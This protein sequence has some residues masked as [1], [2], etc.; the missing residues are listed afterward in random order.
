M[1]RAAVLALTVALVACGDPAVDD[2]ADALGAEDPKVPEGPSHRPGQPCLA[3]HDGS[4]ADVRRFSVAGTIYTVEGGDEV[5]AGAIVELVDAFGETFRVATNC[6][7][8]FYVEPGAYDPTYPVWVA[9]ESGDDRIEMESPIGRDGSCATCH[10]H[11]AGKASAGRVYLD[12]FERE[13]PATG[14]P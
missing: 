5:A 13:R 14:C 6:A 1:S 9:L 3:C 4:Q 10:A 12:S 7:G 2:R 11:P 8:N